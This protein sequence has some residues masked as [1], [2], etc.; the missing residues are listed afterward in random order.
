M[1]GRELPVGWVL[2][3]LADLID[4]V[5]AGKNFRCI[6]R[7][8][9]AGEVGV[10]KVSAVS[11]GIFREEESKT[12]PDGVALS[13]ASRI[14]EGDLLFSR[15]NT[16]DL[17]GACVLVRSI[18]KE[19]HLSDKILRLVT[20]DEEIKPWIHRYLTSPGARNYLS[21]ESSGNQL[22]MRNI[23]QKVLLETAIP[24]APFNEQRRIAAK[25]D[26]TLAAVEACR[27]RLD[28]VAAILK[29]FR[30][31]VLA[32]A[33]SG[34]LTRE[35]RE[36][37]GL[38]LDSWRPKTI[39]ELAAQVFDG[40][41]GSHLKSEDYTS[42]GFRVVRLENLLHLRFLEEKRT[43]IS[44]EKFASL[45]KHV[46]LENDI[47]FSSFI[48]DE[49][50]T[51]LL[52]AQL[53]GNSINKADCFCIRVDQSACRP[54]FVVAV[55]SGRSIFHALDGLVHGATRPRINLKQLKLLTISVPPID[56]QAE[57]VRRLEDLFTLADQL[58]ANLTT[59]RKLVDRLTPA[60][61]AKAFRGELVPQDPNDEPASVL[62]ER[63]RA[64][65]QAQAAAGKPSRR[66]RRKAAASPAQAPLPAAPAP[67][68]LLAQLL[69]ECGALSERALLAASELDPAGFRAQLA[70]EQ[71]MGAIRETAQ[72]GQVLLEA[73]S[74]LMA[75]AVQ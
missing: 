64:A 34:E 16:V 54:E 36:N 15:A 19:L 35:W 20:A 50:R 9:S 18:S 60:L 26:T 55:L 44:P 6:E 23:P 45:E 56:E 32:A 73:A 40:P 22:S 47:L 3:S 1:E 28:G 13:S 48:D 10:V 31:A 68:D 72:D 74:T 5:E 24:L 2:T 53:S 29:R 62:L 67:S 33:T 11:W 7:P 57:V 46:L 65:R 30:Q 27:Q 75:T 37:K 8:P 12:V 38:E 59:A 58:E 51:C 21:E 25:L 14:N 63:I 61:L 52:P 39:Q 42:E 69:Q 43:F 70:L 41:F 49:V 17:V 4:R 66:G 71:G